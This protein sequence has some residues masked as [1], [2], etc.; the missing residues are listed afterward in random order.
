MTHLR[1][2]YQR[3]PLFLTPLQSAAKFYVWRSAF[4][5][6]LTRTTQSCPLTTRRLI[7]TMA[8]QDLHHVS[9]LSSSPSLHPSPACH[10][11]NL[12]SRPLYSIAPMMDV[13]DRHFRALTR[14][15]SRHAT[16]YTEMVVDKTLIHNEKARLL[17]LR[18][19]QS[20][21]Q[22]PLVLQLGGSDADLL[23]QASQ[24]VSAYPYTEVNINCGC[25]SP[26]V[27]DNG[28]FGAALMR[29]PRLVAD[30]AKRVREQLNV[31]VTVKCRLGLD[32]DTSYENLCSFVE[33]VSEYGHVQHFIMHARNAILGG[34]S[35]AQNR[36]IPPLRY[37]V[38]YQL[39]RDYPHLKFS[40]NGGI[41]T[42]DDVVAHLQK[43]VYGVMVG[44]A[45]MDAPWQALRDVDATIYGKPNVQPDG[46]P[47]T[48]RQ[49]LAEYKRYA[50]SEIEASGCSPRAVVKPLLNL[51]HGERHGKLWRRVIDEYL[52]HGRSVGEIIDAAILVVPR[53]VVDVPCGTSAAYTSATR[54]KS[55]ENPVPVSSDVVQFERQSNLQ[56]DVSITH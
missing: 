16:L 49:I 12:S 2:S 32:D 50:L 11:E 18:I 33:I 45:V 10:P 9:K 39:I 35:P 28:C 38:V 41:K 17:E 31:P 55:Q 53:E 23:A 22:Q 43:G 19:P 25:P 34:L 36:S 44:R 3:F 27:A 5:S 24:F 4:S 1:T 8:P 14:L 37:H 30:I 13:T 47:T 56:V 46:S 48:R 15:I 20:P 29:T 6:R 54:E 40:I 7:A 51:F 42:I 26:K 52:R 21:V